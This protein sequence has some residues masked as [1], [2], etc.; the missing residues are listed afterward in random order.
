M[1][2]RL[3]SSHRSR[4]ILCGMNKLFD[5]LQYCSYFWSFVS[6]ITSN[7]LFYPSRDSV[8]RPTVFTSRLGELELFQPNLS[9]MPRR[10]TWSSL[11]LIQ[12][13]SLLSKNMKPSRMNYSFDYLTN[14]FQINCL[15]GQFRYFR[16][17]GEISE[18]RTIS[19]A[20]ISNCSI[21]FTN[22]VR[23]ST[24]ALKISV[25]PEQI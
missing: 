20:S 8:P 3:W 15:L 12:S 25:H 1:I 7:N 24:I 10:W 16:V 17:S 13:Y 2:E 19:Y 21:L 11:K 22:W 9:F 18:K 14:Y 5:D 23:T 6:H 4:Q